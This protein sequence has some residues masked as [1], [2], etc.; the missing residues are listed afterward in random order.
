VFSTYL[1]TG[2]GT[3]QTITN[4]ID[5]DG[6][7]GLVWVKMRSLTRDHTLVD[8]ERGVR[9]NLISNTTAAEGVAWGDNVN[10]FY[11]NGFLVGPDGSV[12]TSSEPYASWT[13]RKAPKFF[14][15]V[16]YTGTGGAR[17]VD[18]NLGTT[19]G[20]L[21]VKRTDI[22]Q[23]WY[24]YH[25]GVDF[26]ATQG[27]L[28]RLDQTAAAQSNKE[29]LNST[30][31]TDAVFS[32]ASDLNTSGGTYVAYLFAHND[33]DGEFGPDADLDIVKC[34]SYTGNGLADGPEIDLGFEPQWVL[35]KNADTVQN[36]YIIDNM[37]GMAV[38]VTNGTASLQPNTSAS[39]GA[40]NIISPLPNGFKI[41]AS[42]PQYNG[43]GNNIL[44]IAIRRG[45][46][47]PESGTEVFAVDQGNDGGSPP[48][49]VSGFPVDMGLTARRLG[50][51][52]SPSLSDRLRGAK[53]LQTSTTGAE[54]NSSS[55]VFDYMNGF[56]TGNDEGY[57]GWMWKRAPN[58]FDVVAYTGDG[59]AGR[60]IPHNLG[61][62]P[63]M[64]WVKKR[65]S[66][67]DSDWAVYHTGLAQPYQYIR[68]NLSNSFSTDPQAFDS[69]NHTAT[70][71]SVGLNART[72]GSTGA[73]YIAYLFSSLAGVS[74]VGSYTGNGGTQTIDCGFT[75]G[76]RFVLIRATNVTGNWIVY[77]T[78][79]GIVAGNDPALALNLTGA[80]LTGYDLIDP[81][82]SGFTVVNDNSSPAAYETN[83]NN[84]EYIFYAIA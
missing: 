7:G 48:T 46:K 37:R 2:N 73:T 34:G 19:V 61:V 56:K 75:S 39:E 50:S 57:I 13:F 59:T 1:Y 33:G 67:T 68:L 43:S 70:T 63:E 55:S 8:T 20:S 16:T 23:G 81:Q 83:A 44:Y 54:N 35:I 38:N 77:D 9:R 11:S 27:P 49:Y 10:A 80:E 64:I 72:N 69:G 26:G 30:E 53:N 41:T 15:V 17:T 24:V 78:E 45:T 82:S 84:V 76:A 71:F 3:S 65:S 4:G 32:V 42:N 18:H 25:R 12:N 60:D 40:A 52:Y 28:L 47:V 51:G 74:K 36:W 29:L 22:A 6:E 31:P 5:L 21:I 79:R 66:A 14:D 58:F 62:A